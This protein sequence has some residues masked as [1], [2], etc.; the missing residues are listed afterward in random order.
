MREKFLQNLKA[1]EKGFFESKT[2]EYIKSNGFS[3]AEMTPI[4][5]DI[6]KQSMAG[7]VQLEELLMKQEAQALELEKVRADMELSML[8]AKAN[9]RAADA[10]A[11]KS[12]I[13]AASMVR[14]VSDNAKI[15]QANAAVGLMNVAANA[16]NAGIL[17]TT[18]YSEV[19]Q[20]IA[21]INTTPMTSFD[22]T[23]QDMADRSDDFGAKNVILHAPKTLLSV[24]ERVQLMGISTFGSN[25]SFWSING[26][27]V[28]KNTKNY[29]FEAESEGDFSICFA[30]KNDKDELEKDEVLVKVIEG[31]LGKKLPY[32]KKF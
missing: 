2:F 14:S 29:L 31:E 21:S 19:S 23:L 25:A 8:N 16:T 13:Q 26:E 22:D 24:G 9:I 5:T 15:Q 10:E 7:A 32:I 27:Q 11:L 3:K 28:A 6:F 20:I 4:L 18:Y 12:V 1:I 30:V 17:N